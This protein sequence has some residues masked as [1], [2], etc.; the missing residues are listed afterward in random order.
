MPELKLETSQRY[1]L[2]LSHVWSS[3][4]DQMATVKRELQLL[5][6]GVRVFLDVDDLEE[7]GKLDTCE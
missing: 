5:L 3:G 6:H 4:Q 1:H 2:F 7:I